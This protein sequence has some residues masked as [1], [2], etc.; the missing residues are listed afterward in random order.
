MNEPQKERLLALTERLLARDRE[1]WRTVRSV[2]QPKI[3]QGDL[4][5]KVC[6]ARLILCY[7][8]APKRVEDQMREY[9]Q[10]AAQ[11]GHA[12][13]IYWTCRWGKK[14]DKDADGL[15][16]RAAELGSR[17]AQ[18]DLGALFATGDWSGPKDPISALHWYRLAAERGHDDAQYNLGFMYI[19]GEGTEA[20]VPEGL[21]WLHRAAM[22]GDWSARHL[23]ADLYRNGYY[24]VTK[25]V[26]EA[27]RWEH[28]QSVADLKIRNKKKRICLDELRE[29]H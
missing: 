3:D 21:H 12:D 7:V 18:R 22:Q 11:A 24:G 29:S 15:L 26:E 20:D 6:L 10:T 5:A 4:D 23:L 8:S 2:W 16:L 28:L 1:D 13:A 14:R 27:K 17:G 25:N 9:L 19:L